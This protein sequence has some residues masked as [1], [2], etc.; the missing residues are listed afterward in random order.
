MPPRKAAGRSA[1]S[2]PSVDALAAIAVRK[3]AKL[4]KSLNKVPAMQRIAD[5]MAN[6]KN[7]STATESMDVDMADAPAP[8]ADNETVGDQQNADEIAKDE[9]SVNTETDEDDESAE[10]DKDIEMTVCATLPSIAHD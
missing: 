3:A 6:E 7:A 10:S 4:E 8:L 1:P 5:E 2:S 9:A